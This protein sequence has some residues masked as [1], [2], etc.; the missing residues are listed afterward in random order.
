MPYCKQLQVA[1]CNGIPNCTVSHLRRYVSNG[2]C[3][4]PNKKS[5]VIACRATDVL[6]LK[7]DKPWWFLGIYRETRHACSLGI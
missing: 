7:R 1:C 6:P 3:E 4:S 5:W 2:I